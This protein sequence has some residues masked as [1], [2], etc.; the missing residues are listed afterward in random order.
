MDLPRFVPAP[1]PAAGAPAPAG[2]PLAVAPAVVVHVVPGVAHALLAA[3]V[4]TSIVTLSIFAGQAIAGDRRW[5]TMALRAVA[6]GVMAEAT[7]AL[8]GAMI[9]LHNRNVYP[10]DLDWIVSY[11]PHASRELI[12]SW[13]RPR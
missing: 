5:G 8:I 3:G 13:S 9:R 4:R 10:V 7:A 11:G 2:S 6:G 12:A 1:D